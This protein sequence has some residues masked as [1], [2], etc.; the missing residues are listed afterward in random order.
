MKVTEWELCFHPAVCVCVRL[1]VCVC[2]YMCW[3]SVHT[4]EYMCQFF[5]INLSS[6]PHSYAQISSVSLT[7]YCNK[8]HKDATFTYV[9]RWPHVQDLRM[10]YLLSLINL[11]FIF[12]SV[13]CEHAD[14]T[15]HTDKHNRKYEMA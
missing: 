12:Y 1:C 3:I 2:V 9:K 15:R 10:F 14:H 13:V 7:H 5:A 6:R 8:V 11:Y 4:T